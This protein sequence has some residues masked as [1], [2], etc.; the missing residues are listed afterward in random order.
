MSGAETS[1][2]KAYIRNAVGYITSSFYEISKQW[3][4]GYSCTIDLIFTGGSTGSDATEAAASF[5]NVAII[6]TPNLAA[7]SL[8][9]IRG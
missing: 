8:R 1:L 7:S 5:Q 4:R 9:E 2:Q 3:Y 6:S